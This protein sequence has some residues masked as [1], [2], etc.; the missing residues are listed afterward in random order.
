[1]TPLEL[2]EEI[3]NGRR[4]TRQDDLTFFLD[5]NLDELC[6][7]ADRI[8]KHFVGDKVDL[9][10][11][12]NGRSGKCPEDCKYCA[13]SAHN[14]TDCEVYDF[15]PEEDIVKACNVILSC[16]HLWDFLMLSSFT[17]F[18]KQVLQVI[19]II[20]RL[21][22]EISLIYALHIHMI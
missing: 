5:C 18:M 8:R 13:Q 22:E 6:E 9:C 15:L 1:M 3:I 10:S 14:H 2:A 11:I 16:V 17:D 21:Q 20:L 12:I 4:I 7:G 19:T